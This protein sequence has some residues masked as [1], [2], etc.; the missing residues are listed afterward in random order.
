MPLFQHENRQ[1][2]EAAKAL[3]ARYEIVY[4]A[5]D[6]IAAFAFLVGSVLFFDED[7]KTAATWLFVIGSVFF[8][9]KPTIRLVREIKLYRM[10]KIDTLAARMGD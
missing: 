4:T 9:L 3:Y 6:F 8:A 5:V 2:S 7:T 1:A 10:G